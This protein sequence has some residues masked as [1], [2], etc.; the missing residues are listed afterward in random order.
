MNKELS[1]LIM[2]KSKLK[3][4]HLKLHSKGNYLG[5]KKIQ[6]NCDDLLKKIKKGT[7]KYTG[8]GTPSTKPFRNTITRFISSK[9]ILKHHCDNKMITSL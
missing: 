7:E 1:K 5:H 8:E 2:N 4:R 3:N 6:N 9:G